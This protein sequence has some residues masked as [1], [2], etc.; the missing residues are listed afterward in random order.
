MNQKTFFEFNKSRD[1]KYIELFTR[2]FDK[3]KVQTQ[4]CRY[5]ISR[6]HGKSY[7]YHLHQVQ[8]KIKNKKELITEDIA[9][10]C[11]PSKTCGEINIEFMDKVL[12]LFDKDQ[13]PQPLEKKK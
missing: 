10:N 3:K 12:D 6:D 4:G 9:F 2:K 11:D 7:D 13:F 5:C 1:E 8:F